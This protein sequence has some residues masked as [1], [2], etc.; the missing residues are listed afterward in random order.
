M[1]SD[2]ADPETLVQ[3]GGLARVADEGTIEALVRQTLAD[4]PKPVEQYRAGKRQAFGFL[5]GQAIKASRG[6]ADPATVTA[7]LRRMLG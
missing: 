1:F 3:E 2:G 5:V 7:I 4:H 6:T